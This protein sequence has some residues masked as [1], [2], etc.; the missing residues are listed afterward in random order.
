[1]IAAF[2]TT[3][4]G[5]S[6]PMSRSMSGP[7]IRYGGDN[8]VKPS[9]SRYHATAAST[10]ATQTAVCAIPVISAGVD[11]RRGSGR[12][13]AV[14]T[15]IAPAREHALAQVVAAR[16]ERRVVV[17]NRVGD[18]AGGFH[19]GRV[20]PADALAAFPQ[21]LG[22][23]AVLLVLDGGG[24]LVGGD[25]HVGLDRAGHDLEHADPH[26]ATSAWSDSP[27]ALTAALLDR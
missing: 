18:A 6:S 3:G 12:I 20:H 8:T 21:L 1:M 10:S 2:T 9:T 13:H 16:A 24:R 4:V 17:E 15:G 7:S 14:G 11:E 25:E 5:T 26:F 19:G 22:L 27:M 23:G